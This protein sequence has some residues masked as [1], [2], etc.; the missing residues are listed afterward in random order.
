M[1]WYKGDEGKEAGLVFG[2]A[3]GAGA[4][5]LHV[6]SGDREFLSLEMVEPRDGKVGLHIRYTAAI[7][8]TDMEMVVCGAVEPFLAAAHFQFEDLAA[9]GKLIEIAV[10]RTQADFRQALARH[11]I[12][13]VCC[14]VGLRLP[15]F[16]Q[17]DSAL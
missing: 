5:E 6:Q 4:Y 7:L 2:S 1:L 14:R 17:D 15:Q 11:D 12:E 8:A 3:V 9:F 16:F 10:D 13:L